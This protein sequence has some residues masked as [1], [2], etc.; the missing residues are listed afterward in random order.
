[1]KQITS[2]QLLDFARTVEGQ[3]IYTLARK[4]PFTVH[5]ERDGLSF[6][7]PT[8][9]GPRSL[10]LKW[11]DKICDEYS[12]TNS[13]RPADYH[14]ITFDSSYAVALISALIAERGNHSPIFS[15][16]ELPGADQYW[17]GALRRIMVN[18]YERDAAARDACIAHFG[19]ACR[20]CGFDFGATYGELGSGFIHVHHTRPLSEVRSGYAVDPKR[21]LIPVCP[22][23]HAMLHQTSPPLTVAVLQKGLHGGITTN[24]PPA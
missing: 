12:R 3:T 15:T 16:D 8:I 17:E 5:L 24:N 7:S 1:M 9:N 6:T 20:V 18:A 22:N 19:A 21:D 4:V 13:L 14:S 23:C 11:L 10:N 2:R